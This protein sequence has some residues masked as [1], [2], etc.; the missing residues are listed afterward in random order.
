MSLN[1]RIFAV[2][3]AAVVLITACSTHPVVPG[4]ST[5]PL[6]VKDQA[7]PPVIAQEQ[8]ATAVT[9]DHNQQAA[10]TP[11]TAM[12]AQQEYEL[13][14]E[15]LHSGHTKNAKQQLLVLTKDHP[16]FSGPYAN[17]GI[18][19][20]REGDINAAEQTLNQAVQVNPGNAMAYNQL[21][22]LYRHLGRFEDARQAYRHALDINPDY[23]NAHLNMGILL[24]LYLQDGKQALQHYQRYLELRPNVDKQVSLWLD[25]LKHRIINHDISSNGIEP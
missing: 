2:F 14:L 17:L 9:A 3:A 13:A 6:P 15:Y 23:A 4:Q 22:I 8:T 7:A 10:V 25:D 18:L 16:E 20:F 19:Y 24:D 5:A 21:G 12:L 11:D 1:R